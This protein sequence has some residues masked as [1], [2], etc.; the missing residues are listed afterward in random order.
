[1]N[2]IYKIIWNQVRGQHIVTDEAHRNRGKGS[3]VPALVLCALFGTLLAAASPGL[4]AAVTVTNGWTHTKISTSGNVADITTGK[5]VADGKIGVNRFAEFAVAQ[6]HIVN[7]KLPGAAGNLLNFVETGIEVNG[8]VNSVVGNAV[9][10]NLFFV[11]PQGMT[12]GKTGVINAGSLTAVVTT[13]DAFKEWT[14]ESMG[15]LPNVT[16]KLLDK[17][18]TG[19]VPINPAGVIT[20]EG[21][22]NAG[23]RIVLAASKI[24]VGRDARISNVHAAGDDFSRLVNITDESGTI[25]T[26][27]GVDGG[28]V[29]EEAS[30]GSGD[31]LLLARSD[32]S[33]QT[34]NPTVNA[35]ISVAGSITSREDADVRALAGAGT[36]DLDKELEAGEGSFKENGSHN[37]A[38][39]TAKV[40]VTGTVEAA[41]NVNVAAEAQ[42]YFGESGVIELAKGGAFEI[43]GSVTPFNFDFGFGNLTTRAEV[44][45]EKDARLQAQGSLT[46]TATADTYLK[47]GTSTS[48]FKVFDL[49]SSLNGKIPAAGVVVG[50]ADSSAKVTVSGTLAAGKSLEVRS[51]DKLRVDLASSAS[52]ALDKSSHVA[53]VVGL[54][55]GD[56]E[57]EI[58]SSA[59]VAIT[60]PA[61]EAASEGASTTAESGDAQSQPRTMRIKAEHTSDIRTSAEA[62]TEREAMGALAFNY[63]E[64]DSDAKV[65]VN[66]ALKGADELEVGAKNETLTERM[67]ATTY[68]IR[69][70]KKL[71]LFESLAAASSNFVSA[72]MGKAGEGIDKSFT[73]PNF[74]LGGAVG[75][76]TGT[77]SAS[78][79]V[80]PAAELSAAKKLTL[81]SSSVK[82]DHHYVVTASTN[83][84]SAGDQQQ[85]QTKGTGSLALLVAVVGDDKNTSVESTLTIGDGAK[86]S[87][88]NGP[89]VIDNRAQILYTRV[90]VLVDELIKKIDSL[91]AYSKKNNAFALQWDKVDAATEELKR[92]WN[93]YEGVEALTKAMANVGTVLGEALG[94]LGELGGLA[95]DLKS[96]LDASLDFIKASNYATSYVNAT[97]TGSSGA[98]TAALSVGVNMQKTSSLLTIGKGASITAGGTGDAGAVSI[99]GASRNDTVL[100]GG[101]LSSLNSILSI[102]TPVTSDAN[103]VGAALL[104]H[105]VDSDNAVILREGVDI[106]AGALASVTAADESNV[107]TIGASADVSKGSASIEANAAITDLALSN[108]LQVDDE[109]AIRAA[110]VVLNAARE[111]SVQTIAGDAAVGMGETA[112]NNVG[113]GIE[114][115]LGTIDNDLSIADNDVL[116]EGDAS[117]YALSGSLTAIGLIEPEETP[118]GSGESGE[119]GSAEGG[120]SGSDAATTGGTAGTTEDETT[121]PVTGTTIESVLSAILSSKPTIDTNKEFKPISGTVSITADADL[122]MNAIGVAGGVSSTSQ[123]G[124]EPYNPDEHNA[125]FNKLH[126]WYTAAKD[127]LKWAGDGI[128]AKFNSLLSGLES[129]GTALGGNLRTAA[130]NI[131]KQNS[132]QNDAIPADGGNGADPQNNPADAVGE[133]GANLANPQAPDPLAGQQAQRFQLGL[134]ASVGVNAVDS[135]NALSV[136][137]SNF[138][139]DTVD[140]AA[141][142]VTDKWVGAW[143]GAAGLSFVSG[144]SVEQTA[145][146]GGAIAVN[147]GT[148][149]VSLSIGAPSS[150]S[151]SGQSALVLTNRVRRA[152]VYA[153]SD[154]TT[155][156]EGLSAAVAKGSGQGSS[157]QYSFDASVSANL[158]K[159]TVSNEVS[160]IRQE[161]GTQPFEWDQAAWSGETQVTG[162]TGFGLS[163][164]PTGS[165]R[166]ASFGALVAVADIDNTI[167]ASL[168]KANFAAAQT[169]DVRALSSLTQVTTAVGANVALGD[170][171]L[172]FTGAA[173]SAALTNTVSASLESVNA[174]LSDTGLLQ[175]AA[176]DAS[177]SEREYFDSVSDRNWYPD[178]SGELDNSAFYKDVYL[179]T[180]QNQDKSDAAH[181]ADFLSGKGMVQTT[182]AV[183]LGVSTEDNAGGAGI[184]VNDIDNTFKTD[185]KGVTLLTADGTQSGDKGSHYTQRAQSGVVSV[186]VATG[187]AASGG[188]DHTHFAAAGS[189]IVSNVDQKAESTA[190]K[191]DVSADNT[192]IEAGNAATTVNVA[193]NVGVSLGDSGSAAGAAVVVMNTNNDAKAEVKESGF[194]SGALDVHGMN[195]AS[196]WSAAA[197]ATVAGSFALGGSVSV[198]RVMNTAHSTAQKLGLDALTKADFTAEDESELWSLAG[199]VAYGGQTAGVSGAVAYSISGREASPG[200]QVDVSD[201]TVDGASGTDVSVQA[202]AADKVKTLVIAAGVSRGAVGF[203]GGAGVNEIKRTVSAELKNVT[204]ASGALKALSVQAQESASIG[205]LGIA[206]AYGANAGVGLG[207]AVNR[208]STNTTATLSDDRAQPVEFFAQTLEVKAKTANDIETIAV[209]GAASQNTA[210]TGSVGVNLIDDN[211]TAKVDKVHA[212]VSGALLVDAQSDDVIGA[213]VG[214]AAG[215][216]TAAAGLSVLVNESSGKT[217]AAVSGSTLTETGESENK[218]T[219]A[220][221]VADSAVNDEVANDVSIS[222]TLEDDR[223]QRTVSGMLVSATGTTTF[224]SLVLNGAGA[225]TGA[226]TG[227]VSVTYLGGTTKTEVAGSTLNAKDAL[228]IFAAH[229]ANVDNISTTAAGAGTGAGAIAVNVATTERA[230]SAA[231]DGGSLASEGDVSIKAEGKE[232]VSSLALIGAG[233]GT[234]AGVVLANVTRELSDVS[235]DVARTNAATINAQSLAIAGDY[236]GRYNALG[237]SGAGSGAAA[238]AVNVNVNYGD[239]DVGVSV[240]KLSA[241]VSEKAEIEAR[242][243]TEN[244]GIAVN[245]S[246]S[247]YAAVSA[248]VLVNTVEGA[249]QTEINGADIGSKE[250]R[251]A[252]VSVRSLGSDTMKLVDVTAAGAIVGGGAA[253]MVNRLYGS[254]LTTVADSHLAGGSVTV[255]AEQNRF[256]DA[257]N[258]FASAGLGALGANV[259]STLI[260]ADGDPFASEQTSLGATQK[261][262]DEYLSTYAGSG[263]TSDPGIFAS[264]LGQTNGVLT[265]DE[266][267]TM[268]QAAARSATADAP[269]GATHV[270]M[271]GSTIE[272]GTVSV[273]ARED[274]ADGAGVDVTVGSGEAGGAVL[275]ASVATLRQNRNVALDISKSTIVAREGGRIGARIAGKTSVETYQAAVA[276][277]S[278]MAAYT[279]VE[280]TGGAAVR[281]AESTLKSETAG[282][283]L[284]VAARDDSEIEAFTFGLNVAIVGGGGTIADLRDATSLRVDVENTTLA[285]DTDVEALRGIKRTVHARSGVGGAVNGQASRGSIKDSGG[286]EVSVSGSSVTGESFV[287]EANNRPQLLAKAYQG[288]ASAI[289]VGV[290]TAKVEES[291]ATSVTVKKSTLAAKSVE[292]DAAS[293]RLGTDADP[294]ADAMKLQTSVES[295]GAAVIGGGTTNDAVVHNTAKTTLSIADNDYG[296]ETA[297]RLDAQGYAVY[298]TV[299]D[300][301]TGGVIAGGNSRAEVN[302]EAQVSA[303]VKGKENTALKSLELSAANRESAVLKAYS[304]GGTVIEA[305]EKAAE[306]S[307]VEGS[308]T[309]VN[310]SGFWKTS[311]GAAIASSSGHTLRFE[312][313]NTK[314]V[315]VGGSSVLLQ[316]TMKGASTLTLAGTISADGGLTAGSRTDIDINSVKEDGYAV[317]AAVYGAVSGAEGRS[318]SSIDRT[319]KVNVAKDAQLSSGGELAFSAY[320]D[321]DNTLRVRGRTAGAAAGV[322]A[323]NN[324]TE[325]IKNSVDVAAGARIENADDA[326]KLS[327]TASSSEKRRYEA[328]GDLQG[329]AVGGAGA[330]STN[331]ITHANSV[332]LAAGSSVSGAG[333]VLI[334]AGRDALGSH[335]EFDYTGYT[336]AYA[337]SIGGADSALHSSFDVTDSL[338][339][340]GSVTAVRNIEAAA[341]V[342]DWSINETTRYWVITAAS[343]AGNVK[344]AS[345]GAGSSNPDNFNPVDSITVD[346]SLVA[347]T[348]TYSNVAISGVVNTDERLEIDG[349]VKEPVINAEGVQGHIEVGTEDVANLY[350]ERYQALQALIASYG[351]AGDD[352]KRAALVAYKA[353]A[354]MLLNKMVESGYASVD[355][356]GGVKLVA[357]DNRGFASVSDIVV[358]GGDI[359]LST[360]SVKGKGMIKANAAQGIDIENT[361]NL[362]LKV[363]NVRILDKGGNLR[364]NSGLVG[365]L[366]GFEGTV[367]S[368][369]DAP[370]PTIGI[371][372]GFGGLITVKADGK[373]Q[374]IKPDNSIV[375][376]GVVANDAG[377]LTVKAAGD[378][379]ILAE[380]VAAATDLTLEAEGSVMQSHTSGLF[381]VGGDVEKLYAD[382]VEKTNANASGSYTSNE[383][384]DAGGVMTAGGDIYLN[385][386]NVNLNGL[387]QSGHAVWSVDLDDEAA[388]D[389]IAAI[390]SQWL[391]AGAPTTIDP[392]TAA[393]LISE[394]GT[395]QTAA[396]TY[397]KRVAAWY[398]PV[399]DRIIVDDITPTGGHIYITG[400][401]ASTGGGKLYAAAGSVDVSI[402]AGAASVLLG[403]INTGNTHGVIEITDTSYAG[404]TLG[405]KTVDALVT[406]WSNSGSGTDVVSSWQ[407]S[408]AT[409]EEVSGASTESYQP[410][411]GQV[412]LWSTG[413]HNGTVSIIDKTQDFTVWGLF[414]WGDPSTWTADRVTTVEDASLGSGATIGKRPTETSESIFVGQT[415]TTPLTTGEWKYE[416]WTTYTNWTHFS[417]T[418]HLYGE[419]HDTSTT[420]R[421]Y[422][423]KADQDVAVGFLTG[424]NTI[425]VQSE[426]DIGLSGSL[427]AVGGSVTLNAGGDILSANNDAA[428]H[429]AQT[430]NLKAGGSIGDEMSAVRLA[431]ST[432]TV[433]LSAKAGGDMHLDASALAQGASV[434]AANLSANGTIDMIVRG[435]M[436]AEAVSARDM[437]FESTEGSLVFRNLKQLASED[438]SQRFD[439]AAAEGNV[440][441]HAVG[442]LGIGKVQA[443]DKVSIVVEGGSLSDAIAREDL[444]E[445]NAEER[446]QSWID[447][448]ILGEGGTDN[449]KERWEADVQAQTDIVTAD[450]NRYDAYRKLS[451]DDQAKLEDEQKADFAN[452]RERFGEIAS[453]EAAIS[454]EKA[455]AD[456]ALAKTIAAENNYGW[457]KDELLYAVSEAIVNPDPGASPQAGEANIEAARVD[458]DVNNAGNIGNEVDQ[459][460]YSFDDLD[461]STSK[462]LEAF[463]MLSRADVSDVIWDADNQTVTVTLKRPISIK[464]SGEDARID[465]QAP[466]NVFVASDE[467]IPVGVVTAQGALRLTSQKGIL[468]AADD[469]ILSGGTVTLRG[470]A[471][472]LGSAERALQVNVTGADGWLALTAQQGVYVTETDGVM[473]VLSAA[474]NAEMVLSADAG[475]EMA[476]ADGALAQG[477]I[478]AESLTISVGEDGSIG[479]SETALRLSEVESLTLT[480]GDIQ[481]LYLDVAGGQD[482]T[483]AQAINASKGVGVHTQG[484]LVVEDNMSAGTGGIELQSQGTIKINDQTSLDSAADLSLTAGSDLAAQG[485]ELS[486]TAVA[487]KAETGAVAVGSASIT[488]AKGLE[489]SAQESVDLDAAQLSAEEALTLTAGSDLAAQ[490]A[491]L[492]GTAVALKAETGAVAVGSASITAAKGL[493]VSAQE[494]VDL[495]AAQLSAEEALT[496]TAGND[497]TAQGAALSGAS[498]ALTA[499]TGAVAAD[500]ASITAANKLDV[501]SKG[502]VGLA[503]AALSGADVALTAQTGAI[504]GGNA[505]ITATKKLEVSAAGDVNLADATLSTTGAA[506]SLSSEGGAVDLSDGSSLEAQSLILASQEDIDLG[507]RTIKVAEAASVAS[508]GSV[509]AQGA[510]IQAHSLQMTAAIDVNTENATLAAI[511]EMTV[512][513]GTNLRAEAAQL[514]GASVALT[515]ETGAVAA[516]GAS[517]T[518]RDELDVSSKGDVGLAGAA[519]SGANVALTAKEGFVAAG[520]ASITAGTE[521]DVSSKGDIGLTDAELSTTGAAVS[522][523]S[524]EDAVDL[525]GMQTLAGSRIAIEAGRDVVF[526]EK[527]TV[528]ASDG[529]LA[530]QAG[531]SIAAEGIAAT[532]TGSLTLSAAGGNNLAGATLSNGGALVLRAGT[533][534]EGSSENELNLTRVVNNG[535][536]PGTF[537]GTSV[538]LETSG[539]LVMDAQKATTVKA[540]AGDAQVLA[541]RVDF[542]DGS[543]ITATGGDVRVD[544]VTSLSAGENFLLEGDNVSVTGGREGFAVESGAAFIARAGQVEVIGD[545]D[546]T[547]GGRLS[548]D[549]QKGASD[550]PTAGSITIGAHGVL[551]VTDD[552]LEIAAKNGSVTVYGGKGMSIRN[553]LTVVSQAD[554]VLLTEQGN[555]SIGNGAVVKAGTQSGLEAG[556]YGGIRLEAGDAFAIGESATVFAD[557]LTVEAAGDI[558]FGDRATL[559]GATDGVTIA[560]TGGSIYMGDELTV[561]SNA[562]KTIFSAEE[563]DIVIGRE[564]TLTSSNSQIE[565]AAGRDVVFDEDFDVHGLGFVVDAGNNV[566]VGDNQTVETFFSEGDYHTSVTA[567]NDI[568]FGD[569]AQFH[570]TELVL[571]AERGGVTFGDDSVTRTSVQGIRVTANDDVTYGSR[572]VFGTFENAEEGNISI[573]SLS[574]SVLLGNDATIFSGAGTSISAAEGVTLGAESIILS[575]PESSD[576]LVSINAGKGDIEIGALALIEGYEASLKAQEGSVHLGDKSVVITSNAFQID[577]A[578]DIRVDG[579]FTVLDVSLGDAADKL[580]RFETAAG[581]IAFA[582]NASMQTQGSVQIVSGNDVRFG[583]NAYIATEAEDSAC[584]DDDAPYDVNL[585]ASGSVAFGEHA[586]LQTKGAIAVAGVEGVSFAADAQLG[587]SAGSVRI[588][589][590][591]GSIA[592]TGGANAYAEESL[593]ISAGE[594]VTLTGESWLDAFEELSV[595]AERGDILMTDSV[596]L[597]GVDDSSNVATKEMTLAAAGSI[598]QQNIA[599]DMG[600][601]AEHLTVT[602]GEDVLLGA[603]DSGAGET[604][605]SIASADIQTGGALSLGL[606]YIST[607]LTINE[608]DG[609]RVNGSVSIN[610]TDSGVTIGNDLAVS[611]DVQIY[612][613]S[614][615]AQ[616]I[617]AGGKLVMSTAPYDDAAGGGIAAQ[618]LSAESIG[619]MTKEGSISVSDLHAE[620]TASVLR[621]GSSVGSID[622][623]H[624][625]SEK[626]AMIF[627]ASGAVSGS[628]SA[629]ESLYVFTGRNADITSL[630]LSADS[631][632]AAL[633]GNAQSLAKYLKAPDAAG[634]HAGDIDISAFPVIDF[635]AMIEGLDREP[636]LTLRRT[637]Q[638]VESQTRFAVPK[639]GNPEEAVTDRWSK[640][641]ETKGWYTAKQPASLSVSFRD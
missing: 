532:A 276:L 582:D 350:W 294:D 423:V 289:N 133:G 615:A 3:R 97:G 68:E 291:G 331:S 83:G 265:D 191:L 475:V 4:E 285:G 172:A 305:S 569:K 7:L 492:S 22:I 360:G 460:T 622:L 335:A 616:G 217:E 114:L 375:M 381:N 422:M 86:L 581:D 330:K 316:N 342:G 15:T 8:T 605:N 266:K 592:F 135:D 300:L 5:I 301:G 391:A 74:Q 163:T 398:D 632:R 603:V 136:T 207:I 326:Q 595:T 257:T 248:T 25:V 313:Q 353:E 272:A 16:T 192:A 563:G 215:A 127:G 254:A 286:A 56:S 476:E 198:N 427:T 18:Q 264:A 64:H 99:T 565:F 283:T 619:L 413:T 201:L 577:A 309:T 214:Q 274:A 233:A 237:V 480:E 507:N 574:G 470:G 345:S 180:E 540:T 489:V 496:L 238:G 474:S 417:G 319:S 144:T 355:A 230:V 101:N 28:L 386:D 329:A 367:S 1:M 604:G 200:T 242:K 102:P 211:T 438:G 587:S 261:Q 459:T 408:D 72:L 228:D 534:R 393:Y 32:G 288:Y 596:R 310:V 354:R 431:G 304:A 385:A 80:A 110:G 280:A 531:G 58:A 246:G 528:T 120:T 430:V 558:T 403:N 253:V 446:I 297:L 432:G 497:L 547:L 258:V 278:G 571:T 364:L 405:D 593:V 150:S 377:S 122:D 252:A 157:S 530:V 641:L 506:V 490:G 378:I 370:D 588:E 617:A 88:G 33:G 255:A 154:G 185:A 512:T 323:Y 576:S 47:V 89:V 146:A 43:L 599:A 344:I 522:L 236:L 118:S 561:E 21:S 406:R 442:D 456:S 610:A 24:D 270:S 235:V 79:V 461:I 87:V 108:S 523:S 216:S 325:T 307:H 161:A 11:T 223:G 560:S 131:Y 54:V 458:I 296:S 36:Y 73:A 394:E 184:V 511:E 174:A 361:S 502:D 443:K 486:G 383:L 637:K 9:G 222:G 70:S 395:Y 104:W 612:G 247:Q 549:A 362:A 306:V 440:E 147:T 176:R 333:D 42:N 585:Q 434:N 505:S 46:T 20:V 203:T 302:H 41:G 488:A 271:T 332:T 287:I 452:L 62:T 503:G 389:R 607:D 292:I 572:A 49:L 441:I 518:A 575:T 129:Y 81:A 17:M 636:S 382:E 491:E 13:Q 439:A 281:V 384:K 126:D 483:L 256:V 450:Y 162:G 625:R 187:V 620:T 554:T 473:C 425:N 559:T 568:V 527:Q 640:E 240:G 579:D 639:A 419:K 338:T 479:T 44:A 348:Q 116:A 282:K 340:A 469:S 231:L 128:D 499:E 125:V 322:T 539:S 387:V 93:A 465:A 166:S 373:T 586:Q 111:D 151:A 578:R 630:I 171:S 566:T 84:A 299:S 515:A 188:G 500:G 105:A 447:A 94:E 320:T 78:L 34:I 487:L 336:H 189:V 167:T 466:G 602:A 321:E 178:A 312:A 82:N 414:D 548:V 145:A 113:A 141:Q 314:G 609:G 59:N 380:R 290:L 249:A 77:Q 267:K 536:D 358:S 65:S 477:V 435:A 173:A 613:S 493:E 63:T 57:V 339:A 524:A 23:N 206:G 66:A 411:S 529:D 584:P 220:G 351:D 471:G 448:G 76:I 521:L 90:D 19:E 327:I 308:N 552:A 30:D 31:I 451:A 396:G 259:V 241:A 485:A 165:G 337:H 399:N 155:I 556:I 243:R 251:E 457:T 583:D 143:A 379:A 199:A 98:W 347:G 445:R 334:G 142:A 107:L 557:Q 269:A 562:Q 137:A 130:Q 415:E 311:E 519:L 260:G 635:P 404:Q 318:E 597:G 51:S 453:L 115:N 388:Q 124:D 39:V 429:G 170:S 573:E 119:G 468:A 538:T 533:V 38:S 232:G 229:Y 27:S 195:K 239:N 69:Q 601:T 428:I 472:G 204:A 12:V 227:T 543:S 401:I 418:H 510:T 284:A 424:T 48:T 60:A 627:N 618:A 148:S 372:S 433:K 513:A 516:D 293:G 91:K 371:T 606:A 638:D 71:Q 14:T 544:A 356:N 194:A 494:S 75:V 298:E 186:A 197:D 455:D 589:S 567:G 346:G 164:A 484:S 303:D 624:G 213:Y 224:K 629:A 407:Y 117:L 132:T 103:P 52:T 368:Q 245:A 160:D 277:A 631:G 324:N 357:S 626:T 478:S 244:S 464:L 363:E 53:L 140:L 219:T 504:A 226:G 67:T 517:I 196:A 149:G 542:A 210:V 437:R 426:A 390:R 262:I 526:N 35:E 545:A 208:I 508:G 212:A 481:G 177:G 482:F 397:A 182:V 193:G 45:I 555:L 109:V 2:K 50:L 202:K 268:M 328:I 514:S 410:L 181:V 570:T 580:V 392:T 444:D 462:G 352:E 96:F 29:L 234:G 106:K 10:G 156:A 349:A 139:I 317:D 621:T 112:S 37:I 520:N 590:A 205:N 341:D 376:D 343:D 498:V 225:G 467:A 100:L 611:G 553:N 454:A 159:N 594:S 153:V 55:K 275:A 169:I 550:D 628:I 501:S 121:H 138:T 273:E 95:G 263:S 374:S 633:I 179:Q 315:A 183:S 412:Y 551:S 591:E 420:I 221:A 209:G 449:G 85:G 279:D 152:D 168:S 402:D 250:G 61:D 509:A 92:V 608:A 614:I 134:A 416:P 525:S 546:L 400:R 26:A 175:V 463:K 365:S 190:E 541:D 369:A 409:S 421:T 40:T 535:A 634:M 598:R 158:V 537:S 123:G 6:N 218:L 295:Y 366:A 359:S 495:D 623:G 436:T 600:L 564:A